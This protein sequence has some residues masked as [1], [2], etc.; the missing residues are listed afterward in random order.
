VKVPD[1][2]GELIRRMEQS[3]RDKTMKRFCDQVMRAVTI[4]WESNRPVKF[5]YIAEKLNEPV[6]RDLEHVLRTIPRIGFHK[7]KGTIYYVAQ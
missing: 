4:I 3:A 5:T 2:V 6:F 7:H 1:S